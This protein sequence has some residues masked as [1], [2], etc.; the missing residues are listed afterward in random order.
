MGSSMATTSRILSTIMSSTS[1]VAISM[2]HMLLIL[3]LLWHQDL[4]G[5]QLSIVSEIECCYSLGKLRWLTCK[6][7]VAYREHIV[8]NTAQTLIELGNAVQEH[9]HSTYSATCI[10]VFYSCSSGWGRNT[11]IFKW[12]VF[13]KGTLKQQVWQAQMFSFWQVV[14]EVTNTMFCHVLSCTTFFLLSMRKC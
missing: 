8:I 11:C 5:V 9:G 12:E 6:H 13:P 1:S 2:Q 10:P 7:C 14:G 4:P 3:S